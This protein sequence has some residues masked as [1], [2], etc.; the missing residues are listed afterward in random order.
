MRG[1]GHSNTQAHF[2]EINKAL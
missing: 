1:D 2:D